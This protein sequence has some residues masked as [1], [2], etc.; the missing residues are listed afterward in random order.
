MVW[1]FCEFGIEYLNSNWKFWV[2]GKS[3]KDGMFFLLYVVER[4]MYGSFE[5]ISLW[6]GS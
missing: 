4:V 6:V 3:E 2:W 5:F 1:V